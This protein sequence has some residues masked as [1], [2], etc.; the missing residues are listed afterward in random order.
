MGRGLPTANASQQIPG[1]W[2]PKA[3]P[4]AEPEAEPEAAPE[5]EPEAAPEALAG[6]GWRWLAPGFPGFG[7]I[8]RVWPDF[9]KSF[10]FQD[11]RVLPGFSG[12]GRISPDS[13][14]LAGLA[15]F[16]GSAGRIPGP[17]WAPARRQPAPFGRLRGAIWAP[18][19]SSE[20]GLAA[21]ENRQFLVKKRARKVKNRLIFEADPEVAGSHFLRENPEI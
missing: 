12:F 15:G 19:R 11:F 4:A 14:G 7:R 20:R 2:R 10:I 13:Q 18:P 5:A 9:A 6:A 17:S 3:E 16:P 21:D 1:R 8:P